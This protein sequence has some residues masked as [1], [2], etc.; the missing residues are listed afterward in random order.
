MAYVTNK[1]CWHGVVSTDVEKAKAFYPEAIGHTIQTIPMGD[2]SA[3]MFAGADGVPRGHFMAPPMP[4][5]PSH[6]TNY[7]RVDDV[8]ASAAAAVANGGGMMVPPTDI[9]V[10]RFSV[11]TSPSGAAIHLFH[12]A[13]ESVS[14]NPG[15]GEGS[16]HWVELHSKDLP[17]DL[18]WL[19][20]T[21]DLTIEEMPMPN[22]TYS[23][24]KSGDV[25]LGGAMPAMMEQ[26]PSMWLAW[27][28][29]ANCD[30]A[31][32]RVTSNGGQV[33]GQPWDMDGVGRMV[34][35][36]DN[37]GGVFGIITPSA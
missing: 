23:I 19:T 8:D 15:G 29:V 25:T 14:E 11:V 1:F 10:G 17:A 5:V 7:L 31:A 34:V 4:G 6:W 22:G 20:S 30:E 27:V 13:D 12:E 9:P 26:A 18:K 28:H 21:F 16:I 24:L 36:A 35:V 3:D 32:A 2:S 33:F 37:T